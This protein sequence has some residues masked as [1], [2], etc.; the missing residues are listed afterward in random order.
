MKLSR[1]VLPVLLFL[2]TVPAFAVCSICDFNCN[3][4]FQ[5]GAGVR[6]KPTMDCCFEIPTGCLTATEPAPTTMFVSNFTIASVEVITPA[7][8]VVTT[9]EPR[10]AERTSRSAPH[11]R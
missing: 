4:T 10:L 11:T 6:C 7:K 1:I 2:V 9:S 3:C 8:H 5:Q